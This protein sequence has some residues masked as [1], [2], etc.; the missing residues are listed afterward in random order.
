MLSAATTFVCPSIYE[1]LG[2]VNLEAM[3]CGLPVVGT[4]TGGIPE[5]VDDGVTGRLVPID[6]ATDGTGL[7]LHPETFVNDLASALTEVL[8]DPI[9]ARMMG[10]AG[11]A[12]AERDFGWERIAR[13]T[14]AIYESLL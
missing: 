9:R 7:P 13:S 11:R 14:A 8:D 10:Q 5:V 1:P 3:A 4:A 12:R 2:I 6:Q